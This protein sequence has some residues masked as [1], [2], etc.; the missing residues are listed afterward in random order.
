MQKRKENAVPCKI[1][2]LSKSL[3]SHTLQYFRIHHQTNILQNYWNL[4]TKM[5]LAATIVTEIFAEM[6]IHDR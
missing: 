3:K 1:T 5:S 6:C 2:K 4:F